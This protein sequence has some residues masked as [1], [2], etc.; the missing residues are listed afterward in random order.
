MGRGQE[1][2]QTQNS[3]SSTQMRGKIRKMLAS[4]QQEQEGHN[5]AVG[6]GSKGVG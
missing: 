3:D 5:M 6:L 4:E 2:G 1:R